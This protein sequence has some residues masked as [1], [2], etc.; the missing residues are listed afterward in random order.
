[1]RVLAAVILRT[2]VPNRVPDWLACRV[3]REGPSQGQGRWHQDS[4]RLPA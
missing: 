4:G 1:M 2:I 3:L